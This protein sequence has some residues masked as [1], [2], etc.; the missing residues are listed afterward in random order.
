M[1]EKKPGILEQIFNE[2]V[3]FKNS[4]RK[5]SEALR[6]VCSWFNKRFK[7]SEPLPPEFKDF[8]SQSQIEK[9][10]ARDLWQKYF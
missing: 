7:A 6:R 1:Q 2:S 3:T 8:E 10:R 5:V 4:R 9:N